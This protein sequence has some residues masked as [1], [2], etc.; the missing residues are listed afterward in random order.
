MEPMTDQRSIQRRRFSI[1][2]TVLVHMGLLILISFPLIK[3]MDALTMYAGHTTEDAFSI[4]VS[5]S[6][7]GTDQKETE[8]GDPGSQQTETAEEQASNDP[9]PDTPKPRTTALTPS[10]KEPRPVLTEESEVVPLDPPDLPEE[11]ED[12]STAYADVF[13][14]PAPGQD[15]VETTD[16]HGEI[17]FSEHAQVD[18]MQDR[19][20]TFVPPIEGP[21]PEEGRVVVRIC[22]DAYGQVTRAEYTQSGTSGGTLLKQIAIENACEWEFSR[23][24]RSLQ[25]GK[26]V[27]DF[28]FN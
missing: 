12:I 18:G 4:L 20:P 11:T 26:I 24:S 10:V 6:E 17:A 28:R 22:V 27:Y 14:K 7:K 23:S 21:F 19:S 16:F 5:Q 8:D 15:E 13:G 2:L 9:R 25:C 3:K 1:A